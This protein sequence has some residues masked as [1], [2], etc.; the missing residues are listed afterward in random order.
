MLGVEEEQRLVMESRCCAWKSRSH[1]SSVGSRGSGQHGSSDGTL[2]R[3]VVERAWRH[4]GRRST[5][6]TSRNAWELD[7]DEIDRILAA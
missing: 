2:S 7:D 6:L 1:D 3:G 4:G 5:S